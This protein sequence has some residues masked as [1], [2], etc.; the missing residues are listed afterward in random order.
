M[1][2]T[3][4]DAGAWSSLTVATVATVTS[5]VTAG[6]YPCLTAK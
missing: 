6:Y 1:R 5:V 4:M 3:G 2:G